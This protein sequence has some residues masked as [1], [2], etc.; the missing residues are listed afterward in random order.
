MAF[1]YDKEITNYTSLKKLLF[2]VLLLA[3]P[4]IMNKAGISHG[5]PA[6]IQ[7]LSSHVPYYYHG[8]SY[9]VKCAS[10]LLI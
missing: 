5:T 7:Y 8:E 6:A 2:I 9:S 3:A 1:A 10:A 4:K